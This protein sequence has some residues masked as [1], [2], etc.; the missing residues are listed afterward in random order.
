[1]D[2]EG[3][4]YLGDSG[5]DRC[6]SICVTWSA[7]SERK[8]KMAIAVVIVGGHTRNIGKTSVMAGLITATAGKELDGFQN[9]AVWAWCLLGKW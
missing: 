3:E 8:G 5:A 7:M 4:V 6:G 2:G 9:Y 1:M